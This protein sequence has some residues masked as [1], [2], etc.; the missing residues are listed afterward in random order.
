MVK[1]CQNKT[2]K[3]KLNKDQYKA[4][5]TLIS[6][7]ISKRAEKKYFNG[8]YSLSSYDHNGT[9]RELTPIPQGDTD[10]TRDGDSLYL[11]SM[12]VN[13]E[14]VLGDTTNIV[15]V[16]VFQ[17]LE[18]DTPVPANIL[19]ST[20]VGTSNAPLAPYHHDSRRLFRIL[21][22]RKFV[23][24]ANRPNALYDTG[25]LRIPKRKVSYIAGGTTGS[26]KLWVLLISDSGAVVH[27]TISVL[28]RATF[29]DM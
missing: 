23:L 4:V 19:S 21:Y 28:S 27:P 17:W 18:T 16:I 2:Y 5:K 25:Y 29:N 6:K 24:N 20:Y 15:R 9:I 1:K 22:D 14:L 8:S 10:V 26:N 3:K 11:R 12:R 7:Q 13:G